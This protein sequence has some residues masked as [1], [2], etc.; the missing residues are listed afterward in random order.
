ML[1]KR[2]F[3]SLVNRAVA[4]VILVILLSAIVVTI[5][6][7]LMSRDEL[8]AQAK[9]EVVTFADLV[10]QDLDDKLSNRR[11]ILA[12]IAGDMTM[13]GDVLEVRAS[14]LIRREIALRHLFDAFYLIDAGGKVL[15]EY[16]ESYAQKGLDVSGREYFRRTFE[17]LTPVISHPYRSFYQNAP[18]VMITAPIFDHNGRFIG[19][20]GGAILLEADNFMGDVSQVRIGK[21]GYIAVATRGGITLAHGRT[22]AVMEPVPADNQAVQQA[23]SGVEGV[24]E[25]NNGAGDQTIMAVRQM[26]EVPWFV[27]AVWPAKEAYAAAGRLVDNLLW[28]LI[29]VI[30]ILAPFAFVVFRR[31]MAPM[32]VLGYQITERHLGVR[33]TPVDVSGVREIRQVAETFNTVMEERDEVL[34]SLAEREAFFRSLTQSAPIGIVQTDVL[35][36]IEF[37]NP[38][39]EKITGSVDNGLL[40]KYLIAAV[41]EDDREEALREWYSALLNHEVFRGRFRLKHTSS[42]ESVWADVMTAS[43]DT[44]EKSLGTITVVRDI[45]R[46][47]EVEEALR[48][49]QQRADSI[50]A[51]LQEGVLMVDTGGLIRYANRAACGFMGNGENC[52]SHNF[53]E[54]VVI[55]D[56]TRQWQASDFLTGEAFESLYVTLRNARGQLFDIDL[57]MLHLRKGHENERL[58]FVL[59]DDSE[60]RRQEERLS[61][62]ATHDSLTQLLNRRAFNASLV[63]C[64]SQVDE[65]AS[66]SVLMLIDL[67][68]FKPVN[69]EGGHLLGDDLLKRLADLLKDSVRQSDTVARLGG[70]EFGIILPACGLERAEVLAEKIRAGVEALRIEQDGRSFGVT[71]CIGLTGLSPR[72]AGPREV[73]ARADEGCYIAKAQGRNKVVVVPVPES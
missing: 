5:A 21:S 69:D 55:E 27:A 52:E 25:S 3:G 54:R 51:V 15:A 30:V 35:G 40:H 39:F 73:V 70:D 2:W 49:E 53:F 29:T 48:E 50:L 59:R 34:S 17:Q 56:E 71:T 43:I 11:E 4:F 62:E 14:I 22:G 10:A 61:W 23:M 18:A 38:T 24:L 58:V 36:R 65:Q 60:R 64:L 1:I 68:H 41:H 12:E 8:E 31:L 26:T 66:A 46:E 47:L 37:V 13:S 42:G 63:K 6:G 67:D 7:T 32:K 28:V 72:D 20:I 19:M 33:T 44:P 9:A 57:T 45:T 16:P